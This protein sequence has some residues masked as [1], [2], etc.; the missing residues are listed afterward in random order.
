MP[1]HRIR[2]LQCAPKIQIFNWFLANC[3]PT[4]D[5]LFSQHI[6]PDNKSALC[7]KEDSNIHTFNDCSQLE[8]K[9]CKLGIQLRNN[10]VLLGCCR[11]KRKAST[12]FLT[13]LWHVWNARNNALIRNEA[14]IPSLVA[15]ISVITLACDMSKKIINGANENNFHEQK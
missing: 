15:A 11:K 10:F 5:V 14:I 2:K 3:L 8:P 7:K 4:A 9:R 6:I 1:R 12:E 13:A